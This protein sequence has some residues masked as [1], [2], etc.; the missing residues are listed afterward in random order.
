[1]TVSQ[2]TKAHAA[3]PA[4]SFMFHA[5]RE[6]R[7]T[8]DARRSPKCANMRKIIAIAAALALAGLRLQADDRTYE[9]RFSEE[10]A[11]LDH[12]HGISEVSLVDT[13]NQGPVL[14]KGMFMQ[15]VALLHPVHPPGMPNLVSLPL[16]SIG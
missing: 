6:W 7:G 2:L 3:N 9:Q 15:F 12:T 1:M 14:V 13:N 8:A 5:G 16:S 11:R 4:M 10:C